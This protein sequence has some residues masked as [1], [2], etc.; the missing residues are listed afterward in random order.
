MI[1]DYSSP[2]TVTIEAN[3]EINSNQ[4]IY[5]DVPEFY[6]ALTVAKVDQESGVLNATA[7]TDA[8]TVCSVVMVVALVVGKVARQM[9]IKTCRHLPM[10]VLSACYVLCDGLVVLSKGM[11][12][13]G[14]AR[15]TFRV[16]IVHLSPWR[17]LCVVPHRLWQQY[18]W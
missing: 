4:K 17:C 6:A 11:F 12:G 16:C 14:R 13:G 2:L 15:P 3:L 8:Q 9:G 5:D 1:L 10:A 18:P 7:A